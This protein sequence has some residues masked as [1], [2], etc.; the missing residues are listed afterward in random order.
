MKAVSD[1]RKTKPQDLV[2]ALEGM[3]FNELSLY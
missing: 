1:G 3:N 2:A